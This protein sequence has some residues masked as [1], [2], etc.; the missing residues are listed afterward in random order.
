[1]IRSP[2]RAC[3][4]GNSPAGHQQT[5]LVKRDT[6]L[7]PGSGIDKG[8]VKAFKVNWNECMHQMNVLSSP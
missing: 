4:Y 2:G 8:S 1:M 5:W 3:G 7:A 6:E